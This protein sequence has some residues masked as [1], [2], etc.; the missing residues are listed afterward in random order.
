[1]S[2]STL[3]CVTFHILG[4]ASANF[5]VAGPRDPASLALQHTFLEKLEEAIGSEERRRAEFRLGQLGL[6]L[7]PTFGA[8][9][10]N[11]QGGLSVESA[12][13]ALHRLFVKRHGWHVRGLSPDEQLAVGSEATAL[14]L[15]AIL[16]AGLAALIEQQLSGGGFDF[17]EIALIAAAVETVIHA[18]FVGNLRAGYETLGW[19]PDVPLAKESAVYFLEVFMEAHLAGLNFA[20]LG[21]QDIEYMHENIDE[22]YPSWKQLATL[23]S[24]TREE[25]AP[26]ATEF[27][28]AD[29][30]Q[31]LEKL[32]ERLGGIVD[33]VD[34]RELESLLLRIEEVNGSG[35]VNLRD[36]Y[37]GH[38]E[39]GA[40][41]FQER[42]EYLRQLGVLDESDPS[43]VRLLIPNYVH[44]H[45]NCLNVS[46]MYDLCCIDSCGDLLGHLERSL[47]APHAAPAQILEALSEVASAHVP[48]NRTWSPALVR[49]LEEVA[50]HHDGQVPLHG[51]L[52]AQ[53]MHFAYPR[54][55]VY[56][57]LSGTTVRWT[58]HRWYEETGLTHWLTEEEMQSYIDSSPPPSS[59]A[60]GQSC[61]ESEDELCYGF[62]WVPEEELVDPVHGH[63]TP[64][65]ASVSEAAAEA[66]EAPPPLRSRLRLLGIV[67]AFLAACFGTLQGLLRQVVSSLMSARGGAEKSLSKAGGNLFV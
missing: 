46:T 55:C 23:I 43:Q 32:S 26:G 7:A 4:L 34:C 6:A 67:L 60:A 58:D 16:P 42:I 15:D 1:M 35:R 56:P 59:P 33:E 61:A 17:H 18:K 44:M 9:P 36:F 39:D 57:H 53:W 11:E 12:R 22:H 52:F 8:L 65:S 28:F 2:P 62:M 64:P 49:K 29:I 25:L 51:R 14:G 47:Q 27:A 5:L 45:A 24:D 38:L 66:T 63:V 19:D 41:Q 40:W 50:E 20:E 48:A 21:A 10:K 54:E 37:K 3:A 13:H 30:A 31:I